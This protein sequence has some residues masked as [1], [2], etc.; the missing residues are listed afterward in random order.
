MDRSA[1]L[2]RLPPV[3]RPRLARFCATVDSQDSRTADAKQPGHG[4][5]ALS[6]GELRAS[7]GLLFIRQRTRSPANPAATP[8]GGQTF[9]CPFGQAL[10]LE[11]RDGRKDVHDQ[12]ARGRRRVDFLAQRPEPRTCS[13][14]RLD[15]R[16]QIPETAV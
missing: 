14:D 9:A 7:L 15:R 11:L 16:D 1:A 4:A 2:S 10:A 13:A 6:L 5:Q 8:R 12:S 3:R